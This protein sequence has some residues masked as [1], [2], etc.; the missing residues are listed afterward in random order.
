MPSEVCYNSIGGIEMNVIRQLRK[1]V[2]ISQK[3][4]S[5]QLK[6]SQQSISRIENMDSL[7]TVPG[8]L[9]LRFADFFNVTIDKLIGKDELDLS[10]EQEDEMWQIYRQL[11]SVNSWSLGN[12]KLYR[13]KK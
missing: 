9:L 5:I 6:L 4:L 3:E 7:D 13:K 10:E 2:G 8:Y 1:K 11:D 12:R